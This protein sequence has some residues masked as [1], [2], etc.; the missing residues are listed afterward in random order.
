MFRSPVKYL[1][2]TQNCAI[3]FPLFVQKI[4]QLSILFFCFLWQS[5]FI[6]SCGS[7]TKKM[8]D[9]DLFGL[10]IRRISVCYPKC[11]YNNAPKIREIGM[12]ILLNTRCSMKSILSVLS[13]I[14]ESA[15]RSY[16]K[17]LMRYSWVPH[18]CLKLSTLKKNDG[19]MI[20]NRR[21]QRGKRDGAPSHSLARPL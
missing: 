6:I 16:L 21:E 3:N 9:A 8:L 15:F 17:Y 14:N 13:F 10:R 18:P 11:L 1:R 12:G 7:F 19:K 4:T 2:K 20:K 5:F